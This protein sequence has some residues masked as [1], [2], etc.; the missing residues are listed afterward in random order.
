MF[1]NESAAVRWPIA[2][3][4]SQERFFALGGR[5]NPLK[6]LISAKKIQGNPSLFS[7]IL[8]AWAWPGFAGF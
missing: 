2:R 7:L 1:G 5:D 4:W 6:R 3:E 8:F